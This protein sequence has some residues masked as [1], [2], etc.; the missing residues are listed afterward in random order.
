MKY[1]K[2]IFIYF[3]LLS[4]I[5]YGQIEPAARQV[6]LGNSSV[7]LANDVFSLF[8]NPAGLAQTTARQIGIYYSPSPFGMKQLANIFFAYA[9]PF[10]FG[11]LSLGGMKYGFE[12]YNEIELTGGYSKNFAE[13]YFIGFSVS[14]KYLKIKNYNHSS[15]FIF[16][17][18]FIYKFSEAIQFGFS[19]FNFT[20]STYSKIKNSIPTKLR[21]GFSFNILRNVLTLEA[22]KD[23]NYP[24]SLRGG[25]E[26]PVGDFLFLRFGTRT[27][28]DTYTA[29][30]GLRYSLLRFD[31]AIFTHQ[32]LG[33]THQISLI[34][35]FK[36][37][38]R[39]K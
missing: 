16:N 18:G 4:N 35:D 31:Y 38:R 7:A 20:R 33:L 26:I 14:Y 22:Y 9:E 37:G 10:P 8:N 17:F 32:Y 5:S 27:E 11:C 19:A 15:A 23:L 6:A 1:C 24:L 28:P 2:T 29:G 13:K 39:V 3:L 36:K 30:V 12:L 25:I 34:L 21:A